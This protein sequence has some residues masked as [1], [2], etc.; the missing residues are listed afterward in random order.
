MSKQCM[1]LYKCE[2]RIWPQKCKKL[3]KS[4]IRGNWFDPR[5]QCS[6]MRWQGHPN[7]DQ[8]VGPGLQT[9]KKRLL[10]NLTLWIQEAKTLSWLSHHLTMGISLHFGSSPFSILNPASFQAAVVHSALTWL[11]GC[12]TGTRIS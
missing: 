10:P 4:V 7:M 12:V 8:N 2:V 5:P 9:M 11:W 6:N 3:K 1:G